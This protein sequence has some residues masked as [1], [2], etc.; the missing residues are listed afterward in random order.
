MEKLSLKEKVGY[1]LGDTASNVVFQVVIGFLMYFYTDVFGISAAAVGTLF[2]VVRI[3]DG[4]TDPLMGGIA[5]R[6]DT[7][8]GKYRPFLLWCAIPYG[9]LAVLAF[10]TPDFSDTGKLVY[11]YITYALLMTVYTAINIPYSALGGVMTSSPTE[12]ASVQSYRFALAMVGGALV[13]ASTLPLVEFFGEGDQKK[14]FSL[15]VATLSVIAILCFIACFA[16]TKERVKPVVIRTGGTVNYIIGIWK[17]FFK[18]LQNDQWRIIALVTFV[19]LISVAMR[20]SVTAYYVRYYLGHED[21][22]STFMTAG[23]IAG[24][25]GALSANFLSAR[26]CKVRLMKWSTWGIVISNS[27]LFVIPSDFVW[28]AF[29][30]M[31]IANFVHM[32]ITPLL[33][34]AVPDTVD[35]GQKRLGQGAM[36]M[37][38]S[39]HLLALKFGLAIG[40]AVTGWMLGASGYIPNVTQSDSSLNAILMLFSL[41]SAIAGVIVLFSLRNYKL[42]RDFKDAK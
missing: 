25:F 9:L 33:F 19:L 37:A 18:M 31:L 20:G 22:I 36:A 7:K 2:L 30:V 41:F 6:T 14:G 16:L 26:F 4:I 8:W 40:G 38:F 21:L 29:G 11:A 23:M 12:R 17:D 13:T 24:V 5:D 42:T 34:S 10:T 28:L 39:G 1:G 35:Y 32:I 3:F 15:A 27:V